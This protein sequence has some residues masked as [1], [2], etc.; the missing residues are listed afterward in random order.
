MKGVDI[1]VD[2][3]P[4]SQHDFQSHFLSKPVRRSEGDVLCDRGE[5]RRLSRRRSDKAEKMTNASL[6]TPALVVRFLPDNPVLEA[7]GR[8]PQPVGASLV[9]SGRCSSFRDSTKGT[10]F[11]S[12]D[13][14]L[15]SAPCRTPST[16]SCM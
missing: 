14:S 1:D 7:L 5:R 15:P 13:Q 10:F 16:R 11:S 3:D 12:G 9:R 8:T 4:V 6:R 2:L